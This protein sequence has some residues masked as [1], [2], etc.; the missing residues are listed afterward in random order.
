M[1][2][3]RKMVTGSPCSSNPSLN[4][5]VRLCCCSQSPRK[6]ESLCGKQAH[7]KLKPASHQVSHRQR[8]P[9]RGNCLEQNLSRK[10]LHTHNKLNPDLHPQRLPLVS[11]HVHD[12]AHHQ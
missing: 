7:H 1:V 4:H 3:Q 2:E 5:E 6:R 10:E 8:Q 12:R 11:E 9:H